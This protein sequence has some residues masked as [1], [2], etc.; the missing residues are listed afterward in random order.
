[1]NSKDNALSAPHQSGAA[2]RYGIFISYK[3]TDKHLAGRF[4][5]YFSNRGI[6]PFMDEQS[7]R[8]SRDYWTDLE[9]AISETPYFLFLLTPDG[10]ED[11]CAPDFSERIYVKELLTAF[12]TGRNILIATYG[13]VGY[14]KLLSA[15]PEALSGM[16]GITP[17][18][19]PDSARLFYSYMNELFRDINLDLLKN[20]LNWRD[21]T[22][23]KS[24]TLI[25]PRS[26]LESDFATLENRFGADLVEAVR[27]R[28]EFTGENRIQEVNMACYAASLIVAPERTMIDRRAYDYGILFNLF[29][30]LLRDKDFSL[31]IITTAPDGRAAQD[32]C[33]FDRLGNSALEDF[34]EAVFLGSYAKICTLKKREPFLSARKE[35]RFSFMVTEC[36]LPYA[37]FHIQYKDPWKEFDHV[38]VDLYSFSID[39]S[40][41]RRSMIFFKNDPANT[42]NYTFFVN[43]FNALRKRYRRRSAQLIRAEHKNW[44]AHWREL[45]RYIK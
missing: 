17:Y 21:Y 45:R 39:S 26:D 27:N 4:Y 42:A 2:G 15:L 23:H 3:R 31:R 32:A 18:E 44:I 24:N 33:E 29:T 1:M 20:H 34:E 14:R 19:L 36:A 25:L 13:G 10:A 5:D 43:Q 22:M 38:K 30:E 16:H 9:Q 8:T 12:R 37:I 35:R 40:V 28:S 7:L 41:E 6:N 11:L